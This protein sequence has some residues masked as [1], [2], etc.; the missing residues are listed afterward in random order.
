MVGQVREFFKANDDFLTYG[1]TRRLVTPTSKEPVNSVTQIGDRIFK[2]GVLH[3]MPKGLQARL[4]RPDRH[5]RTVL[6]F[7]S[8]LFAAGMLTC[9]SAFGQPR[10]IMVF[11]GEIE[12]QCE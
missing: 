4:L 6:P 1:A 11:E 5:G 7:F 3:K 8:K 12:D 9:Y 2:T 10:H